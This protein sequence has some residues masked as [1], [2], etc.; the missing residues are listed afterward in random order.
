[1]DSIELSPKV[2][3]I[4]QAI[5][6]LF[7]EG[8]DLNNLTVAEITARAGIGKGTAYEYFSNKEEMIAGALFYEM[9][10]VCQNL[11]EQIKQQKDLHGKIN[12]ILMNM[13]EHIA[14]TNC[15]FRSFHVMMGNSAV[16]SRLKEM[17]SKK[18][19]DEILIPD[20]IRI[21][22]EEEMENAKELT[23][24]D[25]AYLMMMVFSK[26]ICFALY[27][28]SAKKELNL[29]SS[30]MRELI[31]KNINSEIEHFKIDKTEV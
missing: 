1:M 16:S 25:K 23:E 8:A 22:I 4:Y 5:V 2:T 9:K 26:I 27:Q 6:R 14:N 17:V 24:E 29:E 31:C 18:Q 7:M 12:F 28:I 15:V 19:E 11:C 10:R 13:E 20:I 21:I 3:A 30:T